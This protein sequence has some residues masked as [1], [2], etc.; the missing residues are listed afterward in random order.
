MNSILMNII[1]ILAAEI[2]RN[3]PSGPQSIILTGE[4]GSGKTSSI[5]H[6]LSFFF[7]SYTSEHADE[8]VMAAYELT[9]FFGNAKTCLND[10]SSRFT[11][12]TNVSQLTSSIIYDIFYN[13]C[14]LIYHIIIGLL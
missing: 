7:N 5:A 12:I 14:I 8:R 4:S 13:V 9:E 11:K 6:I 10:N 1:I 2:L 3:I